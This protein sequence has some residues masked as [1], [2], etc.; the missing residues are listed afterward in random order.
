MI[1]YTKSCGTCFVHVF[2]PIGLFMKTLFLIILYQ[3][4]VFAGDQYGT[5]IFEDK[6]ERSESQETKDE[7]GNGWLTNSKRRAKGNKQTDFKGWIHLC[8]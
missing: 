3:L 7:P 8:I 4:S 6:F 5:L 1:I 2:K